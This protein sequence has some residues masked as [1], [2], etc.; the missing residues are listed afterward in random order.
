MSKVPGKTPVRSALR[1]DSD[2]QEQVKDGIQALEKSHRKYLA[3]DIRSDFSDGLD[4]DKALK[5]GREE[6]NRWDYLLGYE[7]TGAVVALEPHSA[8]QDEITRVI[9]KKRAARDQLKG[10]S[11]AGAHIKSWIWVSSGK[12]AH[13]ANT[14][15]ARIRLDQQG[16]QLVGGRVEK[17]DL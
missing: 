17:K 5:P 10:H 14:E 1:D 7:A 3:S 13:F 11:K 12:K 15:K 6:E 8:K 16:I 9:K 4:L 2:L